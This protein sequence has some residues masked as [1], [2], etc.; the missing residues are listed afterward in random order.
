MQIGNK[1]T[2]N[3][4]NI[5]SPQWLQWE[6][7]LPEFGILTQEIVDSPSVDPR[8]IRNLLETLIFLNMRERRE[9]F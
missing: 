9:C 3:L 2:W 4:P 5:L 1:K 6:T 7:N 8:E